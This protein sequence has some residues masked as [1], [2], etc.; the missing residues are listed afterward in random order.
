MQNNLQS[1]NNILFEQLERLNDD[2]IMDNEEKCAKEINRARS[3]T[4]ISGAII[5]N[6]RLEL[7]AVKYFEEH[8]IK[9][10]EAP[11]VLKINGNSKFL[12]DKVN[13]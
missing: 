1:L 4:G 6:A 5:E 13:A 12:G 11:D 7:E 10:K 8:N 3:I 2:E 9:N